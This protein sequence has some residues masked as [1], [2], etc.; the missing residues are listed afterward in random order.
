MT[1]R[2]AGRAGDA[3]PRPRDL[4]S[5]L[6]PAT[7]WAL[8]GMTSALVNAALRVAIIPVFVT[9][10]FDDVLGSND[11]S[12]LPRIIATAAAVAIGGA[13]ALLAQDA[14]LGRAAAEVASSWRAGL[15]R[16]LLARAPGSLPGTSG[17]LASRILADLREIETYFHYGLGTLVAEGGALV[18][19]LAYLFYTNALASA[20]LVVFGVPTVLALRRLGRGLEGLAERSQA[21]TESLGR[22]LQEGFRHHD[23]VRAFNA[24]DMMLDRFR[25]E[26]DRT[27]RAMAQRSLVSGAQVP[28]AQVLLFAAVGLLVAVLA[29]SVSRGGMSAGQ[30]V[31]YVTLVA[32]VTTPAQLLPKGYAMLR[33]ARAVD[34]RLRSLARTAQPGHGDDVQRAAP[35]GNGLELAGVHFGYAHGPDVLDGLDLQLPKRGLVTIVGESGSGKTTLLRL[36]LRFLEP[37]RG[38]IWLDGVALGAVPERELRSRVSYVPQGHEVLSGSI[39]GSL[40][41]GREVPDERLWQVLREVRLARLVRSLPGGLDHELR[42]DGAGLSGGQRQRLA[43]ARALLTEPDVLLLDEPTS[44]LDARGEAELVRALR[45]QAEHRLVLAVAHRPALTRAA[46]LV[47]ELS[48]G[49]LRAFGPGLGDDLRQGARR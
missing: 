44:N 36:L 3:P 9:P 18:A 5:L 22:H 10:V 40:L 48:A 16:R 1:G 34:R 41:M 6:L 17:G 35:T 32:L 27:R 43:L 29:R 31:S 24:D 4:P 37:E 33:Q 2:R 26:N 12:M 28:I 15:Y 47:Y 38:R 14:M 13:L 20:M 42:E 23:T 45:G 46:D 21:G 7:P 30:L 39:R 49:R 8:G 25:P 19:I 11:L